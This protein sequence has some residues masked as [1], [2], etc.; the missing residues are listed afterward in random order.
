VLPWSTE[1]AGRI[2]QDV[3]DSRLLRG[4][5]LGD[6][7]QRP[8]LVYVPP[9][10]DSEPG[11]R[12][13]VVY[14][15]QGYSGHVGMWFNR[16]PF[17]Q[18]YVELADALFASGTA[19]PALMVFVDGWTAYGGSQFLDSPGTGR[20]HSYLC[21][22]I[23]PWVDARYRTIPCPAHRAITGKSSGGYA[24]MVT[25]MLRPDLFGALATHAGDAAFDVGYRAELPRRARLLRNHYGGDYAEFLADF[26]GRPAGT[27]AW[28]IDLIEVYAYAAAYS[29]DDDGTVCVPFDNI[30]AIVP[31]VWQRWLSHDPVVM[32]GEARYAEALRSQRAI[33]ID[34]GD[35]DEYFLDIGAAA[36]RRAVAAAGVP[37][38]RVHFELFDAGH[39]FTEHRYALALG[40]LCNRMAG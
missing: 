17:R 15:V 28:D 9:G 1:L 13:P 11:R 14:V 10:Y 20:Y 26:R 3:F 12:Y 32:A 24:A 22:E 36:F 37:A 4:N 21:D 30:G 18:T 34:A 6:P 38:D 5:P 2:D 19:P 40:W 39:S 23:V 35:R 25:P 7:H 16:A 8:L 27:K 31:E 29:A 33:W